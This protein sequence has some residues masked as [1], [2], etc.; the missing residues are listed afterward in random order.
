MFAVL[1]AIGVRTIGAIYRRVRRFLPVTGP[2]LYSGYAGPGTRRLGDQSFARFA[3]ELLAEITHQPDYEPALLEGL[4]RAVQAGDRI[5]V[6][7]GGHG[8]TAVHAAKLAGAGGSVICFEALAE[9]IDDIERSSFRNGVA[10]QVEVRHAIVSALFDIQGTPATD[11]VQPED[12][13][14][15]DVLELDCEGAERLILKAMNIR[16]R[17]IIVETHGVY[18]APT[19]IIRSQLEGL[20]YS[21]T[22]LGFAEP[23][24]AEVCLRHD[25]CVLLGLRG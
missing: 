13:P 21:V 11:I 1:P 25:I 18:G 14:A 10:H 24:L 19:A 2:A 3:P 16:P 5:T 23:R 8:I 17:A 7:G 20:S 12:L 15:C 6:I 9:R 4:T 22:D